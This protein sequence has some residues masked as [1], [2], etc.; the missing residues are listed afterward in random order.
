MTVPAGAVQGSMM[1]SVEPVSSSAFGIGDGSENPVLVTLHPD[2]VTFQ[3]PVTVQ[4]T[5]T[6]NVAPG[7]VDGIGPPLLPEADLQVWRNGTALTGRCGDPTYQ[8]PLCTTA[9]CD[10]AAD[11]WTI[12]VTHFSE[13]M[14]GRGPCVPATNPSLQVKKFGPPVGDDGLALKG[15]FSVPHVTLADIDPLNHGLEVA[16]DDV[17]GNLFDV[18]L[19][20]G[21]LDPV[22]RVGWKS[23]KTGTAST[24]IDKSASPLAGIVKLSLKQK[25]SGAPFQLKITGK[26]GS[27]SGT[28]PLE[29]RVIFPA[30]RQC[31][32]FEFSG[33]PGPSCTAAGTTLK[34]K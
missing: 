18:T 16:L 4:F 8:A 21:A 24:Y 12:A 11:T 20:A 23:N 28:P 5:W 30:A 13:Y 1:F 10:M 26:L 25:Q 15:Q 9:C 31:A 2:N 29:A 34:C 33:P 17:T 32:A 3:V 7:Y 22:A 6:D 19:P 14:V 27:Y